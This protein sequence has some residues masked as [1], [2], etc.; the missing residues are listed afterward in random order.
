VTI[1][2][3]DDWWTYDGISGK[4]FLLLH[5]RTF[6]SLFVHFFQPENGEPCDSFGTAIQERNS[7]LGNF[8]FFTT[9][10]SAMALLSM[11]HSSTPYLP[12][13]FVQW[14][15]PDFEARESDFVHV[16]AKDGF[17]SVHPLF[18]PSFRVLGK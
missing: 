2:S 8:M 11:L 1:A 10:C 15:V 5:C 9:P 6:F 13:G 14:P 3:W 7:F 4:F 18:S 17:H 12:S 16:P